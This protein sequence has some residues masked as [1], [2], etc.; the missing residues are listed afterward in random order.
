MSRSNDDRQADRKRQ[1]A[2]PFTADCCRCRGYCRLV[3]PG[4]PSVCGAFVQRVVSVVAAT[5]TTTA[6]VV[7]SP[8]VKPQPNFTW[9]VFS[10]RSSPLEVLLVSH[11]ATLAE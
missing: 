1:R 7:F 2:M 4:R 9:L 5:S 8:R 6:V 10:E 3:G 11:F